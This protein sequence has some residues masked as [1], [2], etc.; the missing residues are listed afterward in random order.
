M[1][2]KMHLLKGATKRKYACIVLLYRNCDAV[3]GKEGEKE[4][5][6]WEDCRVGIS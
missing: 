5:L 1:E 6:M 4:N 2:V 3:R